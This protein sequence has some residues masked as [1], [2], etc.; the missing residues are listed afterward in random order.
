MVSQSGSKANAG[1][2]PCWLTTVTQ[3]EPNEDGAIDTRAG[4]VPPYRNFFYSNCHGGIAEDVV[5]DHGWM[6]PLSSGGLES[7]FDADPLGLFDSRICASGDRGS[8]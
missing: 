3:L 8:E 2:T 7:S 6:G 5:R 1:G 4:K